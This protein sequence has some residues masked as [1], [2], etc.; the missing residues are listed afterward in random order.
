MYSQG[1]MLWLCIH[2]MVQEKHLFLNLYYW[3]IHSVFPKSMLP[4][5]HII[6]VFLFFLSFLWHVS[7][8]QEG[9]PCAAYFVIPSAIHLALDSSLYSSNDAQFDRVT[10]QLEAHDTGGGR[11]NTLLSTTPCVYL[12]ALLP[13]YKSQ[14]QL[15][16]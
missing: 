12:V 14:Y 6:C 7:Q 2:G 11:V 9:C 3:I 5:L 1:E 13:S 4:D 8:R 10:R 15:T 16:L